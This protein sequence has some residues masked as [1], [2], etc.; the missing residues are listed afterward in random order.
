MQVSFRYQWERIHRHPEQD[1][2]RDKAD[3]RRSKKE[4]RQSALEEG[5]E[6]TGADKG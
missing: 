4:V 1:D 5:Q 2:G 6:S 3:E